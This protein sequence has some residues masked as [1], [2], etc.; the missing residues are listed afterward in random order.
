VGQAPTSQLALNA[1]PVIFGLPQSTYDVLPAAVF[2]LL[3][4]RQLFIL[5]TG[6]LDRIFHLAYGLFPSSRR[7][8]VPLHWVR[9]VRVGGRRRASRQGQERTLHSRT[10]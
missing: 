1:I 3:G 2:S 6:L 10:R 7:M 4:L 9:L 5:I 8:V